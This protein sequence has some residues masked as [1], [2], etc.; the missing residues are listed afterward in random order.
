MRSNIE[1]ML[2]GLIES[3]AIK[4]GSRG[5]VASSG[6]QISNPT[7]ETPFRTWQVD[8]NHRLSNTIE[9]RSITANTKAPIVL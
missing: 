2:P 9:E 7:L 5:H 4:G 3:L 8:G 1:S 6:R